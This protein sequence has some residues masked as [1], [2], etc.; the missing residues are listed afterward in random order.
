MPA[1]ALHASMPTDCQDPMASRGLTANPL[2][3]LD[4]SIDAFRICGETKAVLQLQAVRC[5]MSLSE[6]LR[7][8]L[9][10]QAHGLASVRSLHERKFGLV[11]NLLALESVRE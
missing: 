8:V 10:V 4:D 11:G 3:K 5:G 7:F 1:A 6:Y 2:G 9:D